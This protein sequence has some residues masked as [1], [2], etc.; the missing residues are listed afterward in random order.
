[1]VDN[2]CKDGARSVSKMKKTEIGVIPEDWEVLDIQELI[3]KN[4]IIG[5]LDGN[6]GAL[7]PKSHE[8]V[9]DG[10]PYVG[11][12]ALINGKIDFNKVKYLTKERANTFQKGISY[13]KDLLFAHNATVG[14]VAYVQSSIDKLIL[15]TTLTYFRSDESKLKSKYLLYEF[16]TERF[17]KQYSSVMSQST[18]NQVPITAQRK[19]NIVLPPLA[20][21]EAIA[22]ALSDADAWIEHL[23]QLIAKKRLIKQGAMQE[24]LTPQDDWEVKKLGDYVKFQTGFPFSSEFFNTKLIGER[25]IKNRDL[26]S[27]DS[28]FYYSG[29]FKKDFIVNNGDLL[30]GMDGDFEPVLWKKGRALLNQR[31]GRI[32]KLKDISITYLAYSLIDKLKEIEESTGSTTVKHLSHSDIEN[33]EYKIPSLFEQERIATILSDMDAELEALEQQLDKARQIK[34]GMMQE[35]LTGR[36][37]L[38]AI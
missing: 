30:I 9:E 12:N 35:L 4:A 2:S 7:Y 1:M 17:V 15:S 33:L 19:F 31:V 25:L 28:I 20:E 10:I 8:F 18:R 14:P 29:E 11:A 26:R 24:L 21:Q 6:H 34:Q 3:N 37:R 38:V 32:L 16:Q 22:T 23:E 27:D 13:P 5:H 36:T